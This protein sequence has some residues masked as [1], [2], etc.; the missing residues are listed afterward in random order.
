MSPI[1]PKARG[2]WLMVT[3]VLVLSPDALLISMVGTDPWVLVFWRG[4]LTACTLSVAMVSA[5]GL[6]A[7]GEGFKLGL[8]G[9]MTAVFFA[10]STISFVLSVRM[11]SAANTLVILAAMPLFAAIL[12]RVFL[13]ERV[14]ARTWWAVA[15]GFGGIAVLFAGSITSGSPVGDLL[16]LFTALMMAS[17]FTIIRRNSHLNMVPA[18]ITS[19]IL[20]TLVTFSLSN[21]LSPG[22][23]DIILLVLMGSVILPIPLVLMTV[24]PKLIPAAEVSLI[25][26]LE[27]FLGPFWVWLVLSEKPPGETVIGGGVLVVTLIAHAVVGLKEQ[28][29]VI[30]NQ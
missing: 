11:T 30:G 25:M 3:A 16:A 26:L 29:T 15:V 2:T 1:S 6:R 18:V 19:G 4:L 28:K 5:Y 27:T 17:N 13:G 12:T 9:M 7:F 23:G 22:T 21:P 24:A 14:P 8:A 20:T 10:M